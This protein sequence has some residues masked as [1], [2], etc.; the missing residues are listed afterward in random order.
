MTPAQENLH[1]RIHAFAFDEG[2]PE[3]PFAA[4]LSKDNG[5][6]NLY[7]MR[8]IEEYRKFAFLMAEGG[9]V[10]VPSDQVDQAWHQH[11]QYTRSWA[12]FCRNV[13]R[14]TIDHEPS[15]GGNAETDRF[16]HL[17]ERTL[18]SYRRFFGEPPEDIWPRTALRFG[19]DLHYRRV[20]TAT[21]LVISRSRLLQ[22]CLAAVVILGAAVVAWMS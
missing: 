6:S 1:V 12:D 14:Q 7:S 11:L 5:W 9:H 3:L 20:N 15:R 8:V 10:A 13:M 2:K 4:R 21:N 22:L 17:Y 16:K 18:E 19:K